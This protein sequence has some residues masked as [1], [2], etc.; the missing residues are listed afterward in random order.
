M[1]KD[2]SGNW[3]RGLYWNVEICTTT[4]E[5]F[6]C[7]PAIAIDCFLGGAGRW[8][9]SP[10][11]S[12]NAKSLDCLANAWKFNGLGTRNEARTEMSAVETEKGNNWQTIFTLYSRSCHLTFDKTSITPVL[13]REA[14]SGAAFTVLKTLHCLVSLSLEQPLL[15][16]FSYSHVVAYISATAIHTCKISL[17]FQTSIHYFERDLDTTFQTCSEII[18]RCVILCANWYAAL[19]CHDSPLS[20]QFN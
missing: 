18:W 9:V 12:L 3:K 5:A 7:L 2:F 1:Q 8:K 15:A 13:G 20:H 14:E 11:H 19:R 10:G 16:A 17:I 4:S 6:N